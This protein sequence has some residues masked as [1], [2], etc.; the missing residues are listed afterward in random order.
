MRYEITVTSQF[1]KDFKELENKIRKMVKKKIEKLR[2]HPYLKT[3]ELGD[4]LKGK[5]SL[6]IGD[7]RIICSTSEK[8]DKKVMLYCSDCRKKI[9]ERAQP[10]K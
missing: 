2:K 5:Y 3:K 9:Y 4:K 7:Y 1:E 6:W 10:A 8:S